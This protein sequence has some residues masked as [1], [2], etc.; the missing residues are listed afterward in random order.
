MWTVKRGICECVDCGKRN[1]CVWAVKRRMCVCMDCAK[2]N[3]FVCG[4]T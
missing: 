2:R 1:M 4:L 3:M